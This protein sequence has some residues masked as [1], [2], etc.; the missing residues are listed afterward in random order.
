MD[1]VIGTVSLTS[2]AKLVFT[3]RPWRGRNF[4]HVRKFITTAKYEGPSKSGL[5]MAGNSLVEVVTALERLQ[6][7]VPGMQE[8]EFARVS[9]T[10]EKE[11]VIHTIP[12]EDLQSLHF[13]DVREYLDT[14]GYQGPT[15]KGIRFSWDKLP[16][17][18]NLLK[19]QAR[20]MGE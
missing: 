14:P 9:K 17:V 7:E 11:I 13:I 12:P 5:G 20:Q 16:E 6:T 15:K 19:A 10:G 8:W 4:A 3:I 2:S 18:I 1:T